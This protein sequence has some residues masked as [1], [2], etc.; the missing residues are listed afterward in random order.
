MKSFWSGQLRLHAH[1]RIG[2]AKRESC[3][4][5]FRPYAE[6]HLVGGFP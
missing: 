1:S 4:Q 5:A 3:T 2:I 6:V